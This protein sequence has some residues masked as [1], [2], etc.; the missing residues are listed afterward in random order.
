M[1]NK[2]EYT[3]KMDQGKLEYQLVIFLP[4]LLPDELLHIHSSFLGGTAMQQL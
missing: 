1:K 4:H 2:Q 3:E